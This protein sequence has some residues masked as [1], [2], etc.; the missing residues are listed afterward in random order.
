MTP[1]QRTRWSIL[2][3]LLAAVGTASLLAYIYWPE[4]ADPRLAAFVQ[5]RPPVP[6]VFTSRSEPASFVAAPNPG[7]G[8]TVPGQEH[9]QSREGR[10]RLLMPTG[11]VRELTWGRRLPDGDSLIDVMS[12]SVSPDG[13]TVVFAGRRMGVAHGRFRIY[14]VG[15]D[16]R[17]LRQL[18]GTPDDLG[19]TAVPPMR[20]AADGTML[21]ES[22]RRQLDYD[23]V[24]PIILDDGTLIFSSSRLPDLGGAA[25]RRAFQ[26]WIREANESAPR[27]LTASR[28][29]DRWPYQ[30]A[31]GQIIFS[32]WSRHDE[33][34]AP[35]G[36]S[37]ARLAPGEIGLTAP[38]DRWPAISIHRTGERFGGLVKT[39][40]PVWRPRPL[41]NGRVVFMT[42]SAD[43]PSAAALTIAQAV[44]GYVASAP[45]SLATGHTLPEAAG[46]YRWFAPTTRVAGRPLHLATPA[47]APPDLVLV[48]LA[49]S[50]TNAKITPGQWC[51][52]ALPQDG[53]EQPDSLAMQVLFD[54]PEL[55]D[56]E[57]VAVYAR[58]IDP[59]SAQAPGGITPPGSYTLA[60]G[61]TYAGPSGQVHTAGVYFKETMHF[62]GNRRPNGQPIITS[63]PPGS[64]QSVAFWLAER[65]RFDDATRPVIPGQLRLLRKVP[66]DTTTS[67]TLTAW[68][69][70]GVPTFLAGLDGNGLIA[71]TEP[72]GAEG[73][74]FYALAGDHVS[75][76]R[77]NGYH[78]C[79]GC[80][81][82]HSHDESIRI[83][84]LRR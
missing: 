55:V 18:T 7:A 42:T 20:Y 70:A 14:A 29:A 22:L 6:I 72:A 19:C 37:L 71:H 78:F 33:V 35:D 4:P 25:N 73:P 27:P 15:L 49:E 65:D 52:A 82:G 5:A 47:F 8:L 76:V 38:V 53:W 58:Q 32:L 75:A 21:S 41:G 39:V 17:N 50:D 23:D 45:S 56:A 30:V 81:T 9:W 28:A 80:H 67:G 1:Y 34:I 57:P 84:E 48:A 83:A 68:L 13:R 43:A 59:T 64:I 74:R 31:S 54:D 12:P 62:P 46:T 60:D 36:K 77:A 61:N 3:G 69:P 26:L 63:F 66:I 79:T 10:L 40:E 44:P 24:D 16:G 2:L 51:I 11:Q